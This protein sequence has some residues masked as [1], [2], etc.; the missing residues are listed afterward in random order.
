[1]N[2]SPLLDPETEIAKNILPVRDNR[3]DRRKIETKK[4]VYFMYRVA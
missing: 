4:A 3:R 1:M 2:E